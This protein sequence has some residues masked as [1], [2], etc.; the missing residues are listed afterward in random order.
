LPVE[1]GL[2]T[3]NVALALE[4]VGGDEKLLREIAQLFL[5]ECPDMVD[6]IREAVLRRDSTA[7]ERSAHDFKG[8]VANF[9]AEAA[10]QS[11]LE[12][13]R[14]G[15][16]QDLDD[17]EQTLRQFEDCVARLQPELTGLL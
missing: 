6:K 5:N 8:S 14:R 11:A 9:G 15:R 3:L 1:D 4:R 17:I 16:Q 13:E 10:F 2:A 12:L 7:L